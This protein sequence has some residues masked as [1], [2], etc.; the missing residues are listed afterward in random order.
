MNKLIFLLARVGT[1]GNFEDKVS[2]LTTQIWAIAGIIIPVL[3]GL[4]GAFALFKLIQLG[5]KLAQSGDNPEERSQVIKAVIWWGVGLLICI[6]AAT[7]APSI[8]YSIFG[9][10]TKITFG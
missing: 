8:I 4:A 3:A 6:A 1:D 5:I 10:I 2:S 9:D 7:I